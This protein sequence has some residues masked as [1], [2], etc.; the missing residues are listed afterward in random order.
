MYQ[1]LKIKLYQRHRI[2][3]PIYTIIYLY[4]L[5]FFLKHF[6]T[7]LAPNFYLKTLEEKKPTYDKI[8]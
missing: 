1:T 8:Y 2:Y 6:K 3:P 4:N 5:Y 7:S